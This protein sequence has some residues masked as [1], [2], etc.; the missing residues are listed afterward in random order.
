MD[1]H[2]HYNDIIKVTELKAKES[3]KDRLVLGYYPDC[4]TLKPVK[5]ESDFPAHK[6]F[7]VLSKEEE[8]V[9]KRL[10]IRAMTRGAWGMLLGM[11][12]GFYMLI[13]LLPIS[14]L[15][16]TSV[17]EAVV[18]CLI[19]ATGLL[20]GLKG[21]LYGWD[22]YHKFLENIANSKNNDP[23]KISVKV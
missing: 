5:T 21:Y 22:D 9:L 19:G 10:S 20:I 6:Y 12:S 4:Y 15:L 16:A 17:L 14:P 13:K 8:G 11:I 7:L 18:V 2:N 3:F 23:E 1:I